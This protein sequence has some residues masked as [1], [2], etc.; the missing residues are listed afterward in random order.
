M[1][2]G[3][4]AGS[5]RT[6][7]AT[8]LLQHWGEDLQRLCWRGRWRNLSTL[9]HYAQELQSLRIVSA[10]KPA[11]RA[12]VEEIAALLEAVERE[13]EEELE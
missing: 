12:R 3:F 9:W 7:G 6:G 13:Y 5:L 1:P 10:L 11:A 2:A 4:T 8:Y